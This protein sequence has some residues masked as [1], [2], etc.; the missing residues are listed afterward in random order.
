[1]TATERLQ[2]QARR[3]GFL[4]DALAVSR[5]G[6]GRSGR[7]RAILRRSYRRSWFQSSSLR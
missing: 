5:R 3:G 6:G 1:M 7:W 4:L 2:V